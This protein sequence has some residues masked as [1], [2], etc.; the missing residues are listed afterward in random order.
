MK[1]PG[2]FIVGAPKCGTTAIYEYLRERP[3]VFMP[4]KEL[5]F[6]G[7]DLSY[8]SPRPDLDYYLSLFKDAKP[9]Q[10]S[11]EA[12]VW[13]LFSGTAAEEIRAFNEEARIVIMLRDPVEMLHSLHFQQLTNGNEEI[14]DFREALEA[15]KE[16]REGRRIPPSI[17]CP[18]EGLQYRAVGRYKEQVE[19]YLNH[20]PEDRVRILFYEELAK[21]PAGAY[22]EVLELLGLPFEE[23]KEFRR[24]NTPHEYRFRGLR[25]LLKRRPNWLVKGGKLLL[26][27]RSWRDRFLEWT[28]SLNTRQVQRPEPDEVTRHMLR[29]ELR[30]D[31]RSLGSLLGMDL[32]T[33]WWGEGED[34]ED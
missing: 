30:E 31:V 33:Y 12:S 11:G 23:E 25:D 15:E 18:I 1:K 24:V 17:G 7:R 21:D 29:E 20:F 19:R 4:R 6:F 26:P 14:R 2:F 27:R 34:E 9:D 10:I 32:E 13:Y 5:Y 8:R 22:Q 16:R 28:E 3:D